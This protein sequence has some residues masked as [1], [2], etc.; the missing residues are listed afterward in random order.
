MRKGRID[1][2][3]VLTAQTLGIVV[4]IRAETKWESI[5]RFSTRQAYYYSCTIKYESLQPIMVNFMQMTRFNV[6]MGND[7]VVKQHVSSIEIYV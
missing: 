1:S 4:S 3:F 2:P 7:L 5:E 6:P